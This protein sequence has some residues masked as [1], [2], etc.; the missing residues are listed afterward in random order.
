MKKKNGTAI[1]RMSL[2]IAGG[3]FL[4]GAVMYVLA[5]CYGKYSWTQPE[6]LLSIYIDHITEQEYEEMYQMLDVEESG[7]ITLEDFRQ[8]NSSIYEGIEIQ[9]IALKVLGS[10]TEQLSVRYEM[11]FDTAAGPVSFENEAYFTEGEDGYRL[12]WTDGLIFPELESEDK[13]RVT[14]YP[15]MRGQ[16]LDRNGNLLAGP[17][18]AVSVGIVP[19]KL[20]DREA[21]I[22]RA[23]ELLEMDVETV[24][25]KL[26]ESWVT[27]ESFVPLR[28]LSKIQEVEAM[29]V[30]LP[31]ETRK[32]WE[33][34][35]Q[36]LEIPGILISDTEVRSY[37]LAE[38]ASHLIGYV[39]A[40]TAEDLEE[41]EGEG[42]HTGSVIGRS[43]ME[44][45]YETEL[46]GEDGC[47]IR[48]LDSEGN[49]KRS[50]AS[51]KQ[52]DGETIRLTIDAD[53]Q[54]KLYEQF[55]E[56][57]GCSVAMNPVTYNRFRQTWCPGS[58]FK[59]I[60]AGIGLK[61]GT[62]DPDEDFGNEGL[63]WQKD[64][65]WGS[66]FVTTLHAYEPVVLKNA[67][68]YSD[69]I[70]FAK[71]A[72]K[73]GAE[74]LAVSLDD[75][76][77]NQEIPFEIRMT[78]SQYSN[79]DGI[80]TEIQLADSGYGQGQILVN[81]LHLACLYTAFSNQGDVIRPYLR[82]SDEPHKEVWIS[83]AF[84][85]EQT[86]R[87]LDG[88]KGVVNDPHG[89]G[90][91]AHRNDMVLAGKTGTAELKA[92]KEDTEGTEIGWFAAFPADPDTEQPV[93]IVSMVENVKHLGGSGYVVQKD[94]LVLDSLYPTD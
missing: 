49:V 90:Y 61:T 32:E 36:L 34:Q 82:Y 38:A 15:A 55:R 48:I 5:V 28:S 17:G 25:A 6:G 65:S 50:V 3:I 68:I 20:E 26:S 84:T 74:N 69:N 33:R 77:F 21:S 76:G 62:L 78:Q 4:L 41:H 11:S 67:L 7:G 23:A 22:S 71:A 2:L 60:I 58:T 70:Y 18:T 75:L 80:E 79:T 73:I 94:S 46:K 91:R 8:R 51:K 24:E 56:D 42:Y 47:A 37:P 66:Y 89:T 40:V 29:A 10:D 54:K 31:E 19:G 52:I 59:P 87:I 43:G 12:I 27:E 16:I 86:D 83:Q 85:P 72:L 44:S 35:Q 30:D 64:A 9:N 88:L 92:S 81:P 93:L 39:Q 13:V 1:L 53:L 45:L 14:T 57:P 63:S